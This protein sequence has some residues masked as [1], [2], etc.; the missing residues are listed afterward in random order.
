MHGSGTSGLSRMTA[1]R[2]YP[3]V[4]AGDFQDRTPFSEA[5]LAAAGHGERSISAPG[6]DMA[7]GRRRSRFR[8]CWQRILWTSSVF[9]LPAGM[10]ATRP[11]GRSA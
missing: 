2:R 9:S 7:L 8:K 10:T 3:G 6:D 11:R 4:A 5:T 1:E